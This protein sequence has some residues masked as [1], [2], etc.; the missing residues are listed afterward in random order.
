MRVVATPAAVGFLDTE[1]LADQYGVEARS[2]FRAAATGG[3]RSKPADAVIVAPATY[4]SINK[5]AF[6]VND[7]YAL[8]VVAEAIGRRTPVVV[9]PFV[10]SALAARR[11]F[12]QAVESLRAEGV[13]VLL[14]PGQWMP[15]EPGSGDHQLAAYPW[16][17]ALEALPSAEGSAVA[18]RPPSGP[19]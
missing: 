5:L 1:T 2:E 4:N 6:G 14:G 13:Q 19:E 7:T 12:T 8:N 16:R 11:P 15:H 10:N 17:A 9:L 18:E 3:A